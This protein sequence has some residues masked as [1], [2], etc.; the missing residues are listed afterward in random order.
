MYSLFSVMKEEPWLP[1]E[2]GIGPRIW[3][4]FEVAQIDPGDAVVGV[5]IHEKP[6]AVVFGLLSATSPGDARRPR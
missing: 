4:R 1:M 6:A 5:V 3:L 2:F